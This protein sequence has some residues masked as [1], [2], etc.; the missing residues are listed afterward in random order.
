MKLL[1]KKVRS[2][3]DK[4]IHGTH[5]HYLCRLPDRMDWLAATLLKLFFSGITVEE[6]QISSLR[7]LKEK[8]ILVYAVK[9]KRNFEYLFYYIRYRQKGYPYPKL[10][11]DYRVVVWQPVTQLLRVLLAFIDFF[12]FNFSFPSPYKSGYFHQELKNG[13]VALLSLVDKRSFYRRFVKSKIDPIQHLIEIQQTI[14]RPI[15]IVPHLMFFDR[16]PERPVPTLFDLL[17]GSKGNPGRIRRFFTLLI[18]PKHVFVEVSEPLNLQQFLALPENRDQSIEQQALFLRRKLVH[19]INRH[20]QSITGPM[21]KSREEL[22]ESI[23]TSD[24][25][26]KFMNRY[27]KSRKIPLQQVH[28]EADGYLEEIAA[29]YNTGFVR[30]GS[31]ILKK[32][33]KIM[34]EEVSVN[35]DMIARIKAM[36][37]KGPL[38]FLPCHKSH[39]DYLILS[40]ILYQNNMPCPHI[41]AGKNLAF[42]PMGT[43]FR[44]G[45]AFFIRRSFMGAMLYSKVFK[46][47]F[48][49]L[50]EEGFNIEFFLEGTRSRTGKMIMPK[51]GLLSLI[52]DAYRDGACEDLI[53]VP[54][55]IGYDQVLEEGS[56]LKEIEGGQK[57]PESFIQVL[58]ARK[59]LKR[60]HGRI[61]VQFHEPMSLQEL[62]AK[63]GPTITDMTAKQQNAFC[64]GLAFRVL[65][66]IDNLTV[67]TPH[68]LFSSA[69][70]NCSNKKFSFEQLLFH[71]ETY[72]SHLKFKGAF[73]A[74]TLKNNDRQSLI[75]LLDT[76]VQQK[77]IEKISEEKKSYELDTLFTINESK[78]PVLEYYKNNCISYFIP[79]AFTAHA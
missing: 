77:F 75:R 30:I 1:R 44:A 29:N 4:A 12:F 65:N 2:W 70:L 14:D 62:L 74:D 47:Y 34:F 21:L 27:S 53:L 28:K 35:T 49:K 71:W 41:A 59:F 3:I 25:L 23:L 32:L 17:F 18:N 76:H 78:R 68:A 19:Q 55:F 7:A 42:W 33:L 40:Y 16:N 22:K 8:G 36:S 39:M 67:V 51:L 73:L 20:R 26:Q 9:N 56:Y 45:G 52:L 13:Q 10:G 72:L 15:F 54:V 43:I 79:S 38:I 6:N 24:R 58:R 60:R 31:L 11:F 61:Y 5:N 37:L 50:L 48:H 63:Q 69:V 57:N 46:E 66:A 64:R